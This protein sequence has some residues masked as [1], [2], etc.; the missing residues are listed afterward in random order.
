MLIISDEK[1]DHVNHDLLQVILEH[2]FQTKEE[3]EIIDI[4]EIVYKFVSLAL[5]Q[6]TMDLL[7]PLL[8]KQP[9]VAFPQQVQIL[10]NLMKTE[11]D[12]G[13][14]KQIENIVSDQFMTSLMQENFKSIINYSNI[15]ALTAFQA[16]KAKKFNE[17]SSLGVLLQNDQIASYLFSQSGYINSLE[18]IESKKSL[19]DTQ[20]HMLVIECMLQYHLEVAALQQ[21]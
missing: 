13:K 6:D 14:L 1:E 20:N 9:R 7:L 21:N 19:Q 3:S 18:F 16:I 12:I 11:G 4:A 17:L 15:L 8:Q 10:L 5:P 2:F